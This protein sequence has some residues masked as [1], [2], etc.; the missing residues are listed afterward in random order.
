MTLDD[1]GSGHQSPRRSGLS[2]SASVK[3]KA[4]VVRKLRDRRGRPGVTFGGW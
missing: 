1:R 3:T 2:N 4:A